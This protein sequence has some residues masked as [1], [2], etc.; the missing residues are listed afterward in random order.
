MCSSD[1]DKAGTYVVK[2]K[3]VSKDGVEQ[4]KDANIIVQVSE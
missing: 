1:L 3:A 2:A 4:G